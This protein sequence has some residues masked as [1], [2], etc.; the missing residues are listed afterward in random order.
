MDE[1]EEGRILCVCGCAS[2]YGEMIQCEQCLNWLH[3]PCIGD[4]IPDRFMCGNCLGIPFPLNASEVLLSPTIP[5]VSF[6]VRNVTREVNQRLQ[7]VQRS[8]Q[9][10]ALESLISSSELKLAQ[11]LPP[12]QIQ[13]DLRRISN[14]VSKLEAAIKDLQ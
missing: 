11:S 1:P 12:A 6:K 8:R 10:A 13:S 4:S 14:L 9:I 2:D 5:M 7:F 3:V